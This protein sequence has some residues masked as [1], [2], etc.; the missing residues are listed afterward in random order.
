MRYKF[1]SITYKVTLF[2]LIKD[3]MNKRVLD[4]SNR[5]KNFSLFDKLFNNTPMKYKNN[6]YSVF[7][8]LYMKEYYTSDEIKRLFYSVNRNIDWSAL[9]DEVI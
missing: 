8:E 7:N 2:D 4:Y 3:S 5:Y 6:L 9:E 1:K